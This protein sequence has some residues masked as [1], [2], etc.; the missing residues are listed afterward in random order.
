MHLNLAH[1]YYNTY[2]RG[3]GGSLPSVS[4]VRRQLCNCVELIGNLFC[5]DR[6]LECLPFACS[7]PSIGFPLIHDY[8]FFSGYF[9]THQISY[10]D[11]YAGPYMESL[12]KQH[13]NFWG[14][15]L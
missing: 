9:T 1:S 6:T 15:L 14:S 5:T 4:R 11:T 2:F 12:Q 7:P 3:S 8:L 10:L 13:S